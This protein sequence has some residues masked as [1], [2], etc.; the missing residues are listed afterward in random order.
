VRDEFIDT[1]TPPASTTLQIARLAHE[2]ALIEVEAV[3]ALP[4]P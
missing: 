3:A 1:T 2:R 4:P